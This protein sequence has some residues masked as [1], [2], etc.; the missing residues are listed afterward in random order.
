MATFIQQQSKGPGTK[1]R[2]RPGTVVGLI[3]SS[4]ALQSYAALKRSAF[5][6]HQILSNS[7]LHNM[8]HNL[9]DQGK[10]CQ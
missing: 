6:L 4:S 3:L 1:F 9:N 2:G 10:L 8:R 5:E 7:Y